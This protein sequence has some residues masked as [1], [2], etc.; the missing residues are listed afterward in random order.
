MVLE[1]S[2]SDAQ[3]IQR[4]YGL[5]CGQSL[6]DIDGV[7]SHQLHCYPLQHIGHGLLFDNTSLE[8]LDERVSRV[9]LVCVLKGL[10]GALPMGYSTIGNITPPMD[11]DSPP[12]RYT[13][14]E[15]AEY[16]AFKSIERVAVYV[17]ATTTDPIRGSMTQ[18]LTSPDPVLFKKAFG[19]HPVMQ[20]RNRIATTLPIT[21]A[22]IS[23]W[24]DGLSGNAS[25][26]W[27]PHEASIMSL[28]GLPREVCMM[29]NA[30]LL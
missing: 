16:P 13:D 6:L 14:S 30:I 23:L 27:N 7:V 18:L 8:I 4:N 2:I 20:N 29:T 9:D 24:Q 1:Y 10:I 21:V 11:S 19:P 12:G 17:L 3:G 15:Y 25:K 28:A 26:K 22:N 5:F